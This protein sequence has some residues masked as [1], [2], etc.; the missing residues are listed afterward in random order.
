MIPARSPA[1]PPNP[2]SDEAL[3]RRAQAGDRAA[4]VE[5]YRRY[6]NE[7]FGYAVNQ[8]G[9]LQDAEDLTSE[10]FLRVVNALGGFRGQ[11]SFRTWLYAIAHNQLRDHW[12]RNGRAAPRMALDPAAS[13]ATEPGPQAA[14]PEVTVLGQ[15]VLAGLPDRY[16]RVLELRVMEGRSVRDTAEVLGTSEGNVKVLQHRA[17]KRAEAIAAGLAG[18]A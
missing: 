2:P 17:L 11:S 1:S 13:A 15:A 7:V 5:L 4:M 12:R 16:R 18:S 8:L 14:R 3:V 9:D 10:V 6:A